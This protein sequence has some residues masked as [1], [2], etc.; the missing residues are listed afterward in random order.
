[1]WEAIMELKYIQR[2]EKHA[3][4]EQVILLNQHFFTARGKK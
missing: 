4:K 2:E 3:N 1:V